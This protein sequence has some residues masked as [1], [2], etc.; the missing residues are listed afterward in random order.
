[1]MGIRILHVVCIGPVL[2][3]NCLNSQEGV[4][5]I[6]KA[7]FL[8]INVLIV[9]SWLFK[10]LSL[11]AHAKITPRAVTVDRYESVLKIGP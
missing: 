11:M 1:M 4:K 9:L 7:M 8:V 6:E 5:R 10:A 3:L 2:Q